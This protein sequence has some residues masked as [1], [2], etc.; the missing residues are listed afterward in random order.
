VQPEAEVLQDQHHAEREEL[1]GSVTE[2]GTGGGIGRSIGHG[3]LR[4]GDQVSR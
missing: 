1:P 3:V 4:R 2:G